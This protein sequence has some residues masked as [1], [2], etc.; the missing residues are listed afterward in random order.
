MK[1]RNQVTE[2]FT[3]AKE[4]FVMLVK[5][6]WI[7]PGRLQWATEMHTAFCNYW[8]G[9]YSRNTKIEWNNGSI[10]SQEI[11]IPIKNS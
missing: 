5:T 8:W 6:F 10:F 2:A 11:C 9:D 7:V 1:E 4:S 3:V